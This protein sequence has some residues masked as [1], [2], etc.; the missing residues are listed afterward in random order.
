MV[1]EK[2]KKKYFP[3][4][5]SLEWFQTARNGP[6]APHQ[7][8]H[9]SAPR[10]GVLGL[11]RK[12][13]LLLLPQPLQISAGVRIRTRTKRR[14][15]TDPAEMQLTGRAGQPSPPSSL[16]PSCSSSQVERLSLGGGDMP[17]AL[18]LTTTPQTP[19]LVIRGLI[20]ARIFGSMAA[21]CTAAL[22]Q[23]KFG[24][25]CTIASHKVG[26]RRIWAL[27]ISFDVCT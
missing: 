20:Q 16:S 5:V 8:F 27:H 14:W 22:S 21:L 9:C 6:Q 1:G 11:L 25:I 13:N 7:D 12:E 26:E 23:L 4:S 15:S 10:Q 19:S 2:K 17:R 24:M 3:H 18:T